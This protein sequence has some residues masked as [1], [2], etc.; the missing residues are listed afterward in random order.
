MFAYSIV[1]SRSGTVRGAPGVGGRTVASMLECPASRAPTDRLTPSWMRNVPRPVGSTSMGGVSPA[2]TPSA[3]RSNRASRGMLVLG[4]SS[5]SSGIRRG[6]PP[7]PAAFASLQTDRERDAHGSNVASCDT[8][9]A[10]PSSLGPPG[11]V[12]ECGLQARR[13]RSRRT[14]RTCRMPVP[15]RSHRQ[16]PHRPRPPSIAPR[17]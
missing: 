17:S 3:A 1:T 14:S 13:L 11:I 5:W 4:D 15:R 12:R 10:I 2:R 16:G 6:P 7:P 8:C 9:G